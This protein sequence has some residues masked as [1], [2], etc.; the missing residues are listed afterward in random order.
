MSS[1]LSPRR[2]TPW[3]WIAPLVPALFVLAVIAPR[4]APTYSRLPDEGVR[5]SGQFTSSG[6][7]DGR[8]TYEFNANGR[9]W[10]GRARAWRYGIDCSQVVLGGPVS[11]VYLPTDPGRSAATRDPASLYV[12]ELTIVLALTAGCYVACV[13]V[14]WAT[15]RDAN[16]AS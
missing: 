16:R 9:R 3:F 8:F 1:R 15:G 10:S 11:V 4:N 7:D 13:A 5:T 6:C 2:G 12:Q 14:L